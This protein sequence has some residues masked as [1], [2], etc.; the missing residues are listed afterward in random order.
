[1]H[2]RSGLFFVS[3]IYNGL[4]VRFG[5]LQQKKYFLFRTCRAL[6][7]ATSAF[8]QEQKYPLNKKAALRYNRVERG[9]I[10]IFL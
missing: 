3:T 1:M 9:L 10:F 8:S 6:R 5:H 7:T 4:R 2:L